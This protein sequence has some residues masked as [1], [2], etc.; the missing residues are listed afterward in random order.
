MYS[1]IATL[2]LAG[3]IAFINPMI[4]YGVNYAPSGTKKTV[5]TVRENYQFLDVFR[6]THEAK[7]EEK[8]ATNPYVKS[9]YEY[10]TV[11]N[12]GARSDKVGASQRDC[13]PG[14]KGAQTLGFNGIIKYEDSQYTSRFG[15]DVS[16]YQGKIN[17][18]KVKNAGAEF[19]ILR[20]GYRGYG[21][22]GNIKEDTCFFQNFKG[23]KEV[24]LDVGVYFFSQ[25]VNE[26]E[27]I[28]EAQYVLKMLDGE[29]L[30]MPIVYD[31]EHILNDTARTD[32]VTGEQFT[33]NAIAFCETIRKAGYEPMVYANM[34][35]EAY[36]FTMSDL[37]GIPIWYADYELLPQSPYE[38][39]M[40]QYSQAGKID[41]VSGSVDFN[42][43][44]V[45]R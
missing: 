39:S 6:E 18:K 23:A 7:L 8:A 16:K 5:E 1:R 28:E 4:H 31:P 3:V 20:I 13:R 33:K 14:T 26:K 24:G 36:E 45:K 44:F 42:I 11:G 41:G 38:F 9:G 25:A 35:W 10:Y 21:K 15:I 19:A 43:Q 12:E 32:D 2:A 40:W 30:Q 37:A 29:K 22:S 17:W 27:A 34:L